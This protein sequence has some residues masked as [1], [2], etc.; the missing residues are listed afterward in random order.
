[1]EAYTVLSEL[2]PVFGH[3]LNTVWKD[4]GPKV[5]DF[6][7]SAGVY[8]TTIDVVRFIKVEGVEPAG[9][10]VLWIGVCPETLLGEDAHTAAYSCLDLLI[11]FGI[12]DVE[13]EFRES[14]YIRSAGPDLLEP[15]SE[16]NPTFS[17]RSPLTPVLGLSIAAQATPHIEGTG[18][19]YLAKGGNSKEVLLVTAR[20]VLFPPHEGLNVNY[21]LTNTSVHHRN[22]LLFGTR[23]FD[24]YINSINDKIGGHSIMAELHNREIESL[25]GKI[26]KLKEREAGEAVI[27][28]A[29]GQL[30]ERRKLLDKANKSME[31]L[32]K[33]HDE[34]KKTWGPPSRRI[35]GHIIC[36]PPITFGTGSEGFT[37]DYAIVELDS[38]KV[39]KA[40]MGNVMDLG[41]F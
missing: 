41:T 14:I 21:T 38:S 10:V 1:M 31:A 11:D 20:H 34:V 7:D 27:E 24:N 28:K 8:W 36:S 17:V 5:C 33:F 12:T 2:H 16:F 6:L 4:L 35:L 18:G 15:V 9:P 25:Q 23:A 19:F 32:D 26:E 29:M 39:E 40:F 30:E 3:K 37:E 22:V 13:V